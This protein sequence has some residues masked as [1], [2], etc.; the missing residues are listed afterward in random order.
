MNWSLPFHPAD[1]RQIYEWAHDHV[2]LPSAITKHGAFDVHSSRYLIAPFES[3]AAD[4]I[5]EVVIRAPVRSGKS[6]IADIWLP[7]IV[8]NDP[9]P[10][11]WVMQTDPIAGDHAETRVMPILEACEPVRAQFPFDRHKKRSKSIM[12]NHG[13]PF[14]IQGPSTFG[15]QSKGIRYVI[16]DEVWIWETGKLQ[17]AKGRLGDYEEMQTSKLLVVSQAGVEDD[18]FDQECQRGH[19]AEWHVHCQKCDHFQRPRWDDS[20]PDG[21]RWGMRFDLEKD[22]RG[23]YSVRKAVESRRYECEKCGHPHTDYGRTKASWNL[24][25]D[26]VSKD[27]G[28]AKIHSYHY[29]GLITRDWDALVEEYVRAINA[30]NRGVAEPIVQFWQK[31][32]A[33]PKSEGTAFEMSKPMTIVTYNAKDKWGEETHRFMTIDRQEEDVFWWTIRAWTPQGK[34]RRLGFGKAFSAGECEAARK[35]HSVPPNYTFLDSGFFPKGDNGVY[36]LCVKYGWIAFKGAEE[37]YFIHKT[38]AGSV[39]RSYSPATRGDPESGHADSGKRFATLIRFAATVMKDRVNRLIDRQLWEEPAREDTDIEIAYRKQMSSEFKR[40]KR[41]RF[42]GREQLIYVCPSGD[43]HAFDCASM[44]AAAAT[45]CKLIPDQDVME[46]IQG[47]PKPEAG[48]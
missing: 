42:T 17:E 26:Y 12:F 5:R 20:R 15:L 28:N 1:R 34:S 22:G 16:A 33:E 36:S 18:D 19:G 27:D 14:W 23:D 38:K 44:Q 47:K 37:T 43:N 11:L 2:N 39:R 4:H 30:R 29:P 48:Q 25:G 8:A 32:M 7:W 45:I 10:V 13:M 21:S 9:G 24:T 6:L 3:L 31:R 40:R 41:D 35:D 46:E